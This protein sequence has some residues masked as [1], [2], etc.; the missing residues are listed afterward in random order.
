MK[1]RP[2]GSRKVAKEALRP[3]SDDLRQKPAVQIERKTQRSR[4]V[5]AATPR[6]HHGLPVVRAA[7]PY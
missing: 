4:N 3:K 6:G 1:L 2:N 5:R 7:W